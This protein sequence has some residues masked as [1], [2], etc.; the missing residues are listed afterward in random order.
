MPIRLIA[1]DVDRHGRGVGY[2][3]S[4]PCGTQSQGGWDVK[5]TGATKASAHAET[6]QAAV[7]LGR[8]ISRHQGTEFVIHGKDGKIQQSDSHGNDPFPPRG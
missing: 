3:K 6:K 2:E 1:H 8:E 5:L 4:T 7:D